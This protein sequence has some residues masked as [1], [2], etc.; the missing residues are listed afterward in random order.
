[1]IPATR[2]VKGLKKLPYEIRLKKLGIWKDEDYVEI[3]LKRSRYWLEKN[4]STTANSLNWQMS[5]A[6]SEVTR[7]NYSNQDVVRQSDRTS[8]V[9]GL[10]TTGTSWT[11]LMYR[12]SKNRLDRHWQDMGI[13]SWPA[14]INL[15]YRYK[16]NSDTRIIQRTVFISCAPAWKVGAT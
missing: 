12:Q 15:K 14:P 7:W 1:M 5:P 16:S 8:S 3:S 10:S 4:M 11:S 9:Y 2:M 6:D 13:L